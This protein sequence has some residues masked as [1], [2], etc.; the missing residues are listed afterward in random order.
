MILI[1]ISQILLALA[2]FA[3][4]I[5]MKK[6][7]REFN[8]EKIND[9]LDQNWKALLFL[10]DAHELINQRLVVHSE[11]LK[12]LSVKWIKIQEIEK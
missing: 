4:A 11:H 8:K 6:L 3:L 2:V 7:E 9:R 5:S 1:T 10:R 12:I